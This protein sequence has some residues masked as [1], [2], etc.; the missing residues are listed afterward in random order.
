MLNSTEKKDHVWVDVAR[1]WEEE[2]AAGA[3]EVLHQRTPQQLR[4]KFD[5]LLRECR[6]HNLLLARA[7]G[8]HGGSGNGR[9]AVED[10]VAP[11]F[12]QEMLQK[13]FLTGP[14]ANKQYVLSSRR[15]VASFVDSGSDSPQPLDILDVDDEVD[16]G[17]GGEDMPP[18]T[19]P[20]GGRREAQDRAEKRRVSG[21]KRQGSGDGSDSV[22]GSKRRKSSILESAC[23]QSA[24][25]AA[26]AAMESTT[27]LV[28]CMERGS[29]KQLQMWEQ[30]CAAQDRRI[31]K[32]CETIGRGL[33]DLANAI[34]GSHM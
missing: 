34:K 5:A 9:E 10:L 33:A 32:L 14:L 8:T 22:S 26:D 19:E 11:A 27:M 12:F 29:A 6:K 17:W 4:N 18:T 30:E 13:G 16:E 7:N 25:M 21:S 31:D 1:Q 3:V 28:Q 24:S 2:R 20:I 15:G 23:K